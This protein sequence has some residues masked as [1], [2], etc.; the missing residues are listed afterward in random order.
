MSYTIIYYLFYINN[1]IKKVIK[2]KGAMQE[3]QKK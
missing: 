1:I 2:L 3:L